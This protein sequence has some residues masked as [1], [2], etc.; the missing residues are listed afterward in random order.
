MFTQSVH[1][2]CDSTW[3]EDSGVQPHV[4]QDERG[5]QTDGAGAGHQHPLRVPQH[6]LL[7]EEDL[8]DALLYDAQGL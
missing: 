5:Q 1:T 7:D 8:G 6:P 3:G 2:E 4:P